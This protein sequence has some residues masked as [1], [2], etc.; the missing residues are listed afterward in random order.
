MAT[1]LPSTRSRARPDSSAV[2]KSPDGAPSPPR[3]RAARHQR[4]EPQSRGARTTA[5]RPG[6]PVTFAGRQI[7]LSNLQKVLYPESGFTKGQVIDYYA[8]IAPTIL[9]YLKGR[10]LTLKRYPDGVD[11]PFFYEKM[12]PSHRPDW[13][14]TTRIASTGKRQY[15]QYCVVDDAATLIWTANLASLELHTLLGTVQHPLRPSFMVFDHDPGP[16]AT[17]LDC[18]NVALRFRGLLKD[19]SLQSFPKTS[20]GKGLHL[21]VP[22]NTPV[23]FEQTKSL[24]RAMAQLLERDDPAHITSNMR[25]DLRVGKV[26]VD[27]SQND[28]HKTTVTA[29]SLR[30]REFPSVSTPV[31]W[32]ELAEAVRRADPSHLVFGSQ[33]VLQ[34]VA[35]DGDIFNPV[36][37]LHQTLPSL[38]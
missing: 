14:T 18:A 12:C 29:Y 36:T 24:S 21:Y 26:F 30:A 34:R 13:V 8:R 33:Q 22:L 17:L 23:T 7:K 19:L 35:R 27:W 25:K 38:R 31:H 1:M 9:P 37:T 20:G 5:P 3:G 6:V 15:V 32:E 4:S 16:G 10:P 11:H 2:R 28:H